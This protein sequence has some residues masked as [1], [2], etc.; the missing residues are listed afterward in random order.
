[1]VHLQ[2]VG[3]GI[4]LL[5]FNS[6]PAS[7]NYSGWRGLRNAFRAATDE[8]PTCLVSSLFDNG[9]RLT[10]DCADLQ[11]LMNSEINMAGLDLKIRVNP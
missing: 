6:R 11:G 8:R 10:A 5:H 4:R 3:E 9:R 2:F 7:N 1:M